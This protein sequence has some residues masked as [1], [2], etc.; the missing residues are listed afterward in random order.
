[1]SIQEKDGVVNSEPEQESVGNALDTAKS[2]EG[3]K[4]CMIVYHVKIT[5][6]TI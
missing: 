1:M 5:V 6:I 4:L 3:D 2:L